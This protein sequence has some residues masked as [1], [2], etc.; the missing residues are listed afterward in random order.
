MTQDSAMKRKMGW[1]TRYKAR[2]KVMRN[3]ETANLIRMPPV[4][5]RL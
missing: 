1:R 3:R 4:S 5:L 2:K